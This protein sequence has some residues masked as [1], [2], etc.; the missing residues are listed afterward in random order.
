M[1][2]D[3]DQFNRHHICIRSYLSSFFSWQ[4][5]K[6]TTTQVDELIT[7]MSPICHYVHDFQ[8]FYPKIKVDGGECGG[9]FQH[10]Q[11]K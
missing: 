5:T 1:K 4:N 10:L 8:T 7:K 11:R 9:H 3:I 6:H 2:Y